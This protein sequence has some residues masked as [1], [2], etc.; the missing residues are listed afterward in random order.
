[1][2]HKIDW[3]TKAKKKAGIEAIKHIEDGFVVGLGSGSTV[4]FAIEALGKKIEKEKID[5]IGIPTSY[6]S[7]LLAV[8]HGIKISTLDENPN[9]DITI[10]GADQVDDQLNL[11]KGMGGALLRE[12]IIALASKNNI[13][14]ADET[15]KVKKLGTDNHPV[16]IEVLPFAL[17]Q[18]KDKLVEIGGEPLLREGTGKV[19]PIITDNG[20]V[21]LDSIFGI[22]NNPAD[23]N[24]RI[25]MITGVIETGL[26]ID[27]T[28]ILY[29]GTSTTVKKIFR[30]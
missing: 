3:I 15:K 4:A 20:N 12:K 24:T 26:F 17:A 11:I 13:I 21:I 28:N 30:K 23:L 9:I 18:V 10:D 1:L 25:K 6:Q 5:I 22:I 29:V 8:K 7:F 27:T 14:I 2:T 19:G 16:P